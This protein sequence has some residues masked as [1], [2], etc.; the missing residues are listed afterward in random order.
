MWMMC[1]GQSKMLQLPWKMAKSD[2]A[3]ALPTTDRLRIVLEFG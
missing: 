3:E 2:K 1:D